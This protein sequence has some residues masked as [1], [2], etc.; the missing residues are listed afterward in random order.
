MQKQKFQTLG[1]D[2]CADCE[3]M[4][5]ETDGEILICTEC[6]IEL[7]EYDEYQPDEAQEWHDFDPDC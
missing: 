7:A 1:M 5:Q 2:G 3:W 4:A 6:E